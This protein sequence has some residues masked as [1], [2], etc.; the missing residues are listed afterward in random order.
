VIVQRMSKTHAQVVA[1]LELGL[2]VSD[3]I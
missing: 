2:G 3:N 1:L